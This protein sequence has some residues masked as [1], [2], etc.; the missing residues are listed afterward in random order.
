MRRQRRLTVLSTVLVL[1]ASAV[2]TA[3]G[4]AVAVG[5][6]AAAPVVNLSD[7][8]PWG[9][10]V[11]TGIAVAPRGRVA[12]V[13]MQPDDGGSS[14]AVAF[15]RTG[16]PWSPARTVPGSRGAAQAEVAFDGGGEAV[17]AW[18]A[19]RRV[20]A[21]RRSV[22]GTWGRPRIL[23]RSVRP[24]EVNPPGGVDLAVNAR[25]RAVASWQGQR[26][27]AAVGFPDG[28]WGK[29]RAVLPDGAAVSTSRLA[30]RRGPTSSNGTT[31]A[32]IDRWGTATVVWRVGGGWVPRTVVEVH[33]RVGR[34]WSEPR[35]LSG[36]EWA[37]AP[38]QVAARR[39][40]EL[41]VAWASTL[42]RGTA[43]RLARGQRSATWTR[44]QTL[45]IGNTEIGKLR[46]A[47]DGT[48]KVTVAWTNTRGAFWVAEHVRGE[49]WSRIRR[50][51]PPGSEGDEWGL[52]A[53]EAGD[54]LIGASGAGAP[55]AVWV[56][57]R[58]PEG[59][60]SGVRVVTDRAGEA[61]GPAVAVGPRGLGALVWALRQ[62]DGS[63]GTVQARVLPR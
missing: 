23:F 19:P 61:R 51:A 25:G 43:I 30:V 7:A 41:A 48:G 34:P 57:R 60:W 31:T 39:S 50:V 33:K 9:S 11:P 12:A 47:M 32:V 62:P 14:I 3:T 6:S 40:G 24:V 10:L 28:T 16:G 44:P 55:K 17:V 29:A 36:E 52:V 53:N 46:V 27:M 42:K 58:S 45:P 4:A 49:G 26:L 37:A 5:G 18:M 59:R 8:S 20:G 21:V 35:A 1:A 2:G 38:E 63:T 56:V 54:V 15:R 22:D 13:W